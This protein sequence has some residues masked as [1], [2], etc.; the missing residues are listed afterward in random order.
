M[1]IGSDHPHRSDAHGANV[2]VVE[3]GGY[4]GTQPPA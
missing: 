1:R 4:G 3:I 2:G